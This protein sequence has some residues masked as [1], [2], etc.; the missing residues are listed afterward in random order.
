MSFSAAGDV[1]PLAGTKSRTA[2]LALVGVVFVAGFASSVG[3]EASAALRYT[4]KVRVVRRGLKLMKITDAFGPNRIKVL[5]IDPSS[6]MTIDVALSNEEIPGHERT[7]SMAGR[8]GAIAAINGNFGMSSG[9]PV[10]L[11]AEDGALHTN[12]IA[13]GSDAVFAISR[14]ERS[15]YVGYRNVRVAA[16][17]LTTGASWDV[18]D[19]NDH[20]PRRRRITGYT[21]VGGNAAPPP[22]DACSIRLMPS[23]KLAWGTGKIG[24]GKTYEVD[25]VRCARQRLSPQNGVVLAAARGTS[26]AKAIAAV[27]PGQSFRLQ[28]SLAGWAGVMDAIGGS[29]VL[30]QDGV[31][32][33]EQCSGYVCQRHPRTG[34]GVTPQGDI[35]LAVVDGRRSG[36]VGMDLV[37]FGRLFRWL[38]AESAMNLDGGGSATMVVKGRVVNS[39]TDAGGERAVVSSLL[40]L[41]G[42]DSREAQ[43]IS[44]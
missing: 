14:D 31:V 3:P 35:L 1:S 10:G 8:H 11:L 23:T 12:A 33:A 36:S 16:E 39:P 22:E 20:D 30:M 40:V 43:P 7:S 42:A 25:I 21:D 13:P 28:W 29:P 26:A 15:T 37:D 4:K 27:S 5:K 9:R 2:A 17:N 24:V 6:R 18:V 34:V 44:P 19:W 41:P 32:T 38:G